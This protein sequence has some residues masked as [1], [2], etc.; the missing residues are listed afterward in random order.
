MSHVTKKTENKI[1]FLSFR[2]ITEAPN[3]TGLQGRIDRQSI[4]FNDEFDR[5]D[6]PRGLGFFNDK[7]EPG[8]ERYGFFLI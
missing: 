3:A 2:L 4:R 1:L 8:A 6:N 5:I 7:P